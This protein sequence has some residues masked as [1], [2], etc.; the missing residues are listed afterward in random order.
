MRVTWGEHKW[1]ESAERDARS[2]QSLC[3]I[4][5]SGLQEREVTAAITAYE[6]HGWLLDQLTATEPPDTD[7]ADTAVTYHVLFRRD[8]AQN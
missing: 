8:G 3:V 6:T 1:R 2:G 7:T 5:L 4:R